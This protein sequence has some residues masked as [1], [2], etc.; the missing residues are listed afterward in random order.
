MSEESI[1]PS[2]EEILIET[3]NKNVEI[4]CNGN[5]ESRIASLKI[6]VDELKKSTSSMTSVPKPIKH[7]LPYLKELIQAYDTFS[8]EQYRTILAD[9]LSL[10]TIINVD[11]NYDVLLYRLASPTENI[12]F[13]GHEYVRCLTR[14]LLRAAANP[15]ELPANTD[16]TSLSDQIA[17]YYMSQKDEPDVCDLYL[18][19]GCLEKLVSLVDSESYSRTCTYLLQLYD[20]IEY[21]LH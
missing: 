13:W 1:Q 3:I 11:S 17:K 20:Y 19:L 10:L 12:G 4:V 15:K 21:C 14:V 2:S 16:L 7:L 5:L 8:N 6:I 18:E 9:L